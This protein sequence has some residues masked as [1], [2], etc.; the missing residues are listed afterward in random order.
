MA[1]PRLQLHELFLT[2]TDNAYFQAPPNTGMRYPCILYS[3]DADSTQHADNELYRDAKRYQVMVIDR[4]PDSDLAE[5]VRRLQY[6]SFDRSYKA[7][8]LNHYV[9]SLYF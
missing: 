6:T 2:L 5:K 9:F 3:W 4:D 7:D 1:P 8:D